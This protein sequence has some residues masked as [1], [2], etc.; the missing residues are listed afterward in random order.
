MNEVIRK[1]PFKNL[2]N[3]EHLQFMRS[4]RDVFGKHT[5][6]NEDFGSL[7]MEFKEKITMEDNSMYTER[8]NDKVRE[9]ND[10][11]DYR[12]SLHSKLFY[13]VKSITFDKK[14]PRLEDAQAVLKVLKETGNPSHLSENAESAMLTTLCRRLL[15]LA[16]QLKNISALDI[17]DMLFQANENFIKIEKEYRDLL[18]E[19]KSDASYMSMSAARRQTDPVYRAMINAINGYAGVP[20]KKETCR[21]LIIEMNV[22]VA[23]YDAVLTARKTREEDGETPPAETPAAETDNKPEPEE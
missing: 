17:L 20:A 22:L 4:S 8:N 21:E 13:H 18:A 16:T 1:F 6:V 19:Q 10:A 11:D 23:R 12:D 3:P 7:F 5:V 2:R 14:D 15:P 9:K